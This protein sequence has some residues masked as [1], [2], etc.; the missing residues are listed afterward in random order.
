[1]WLCKRKKKPCVSY[2]LH[3]PSSRSRG[4]TSCPDEPPSG[5]TASVTGCLSTRETARRVMKS[6]FNT[7]TQILIH[8][9]PMLC[10]ILTLLL[11]ACSTF[12]TP[13]TTTRLF[14]PLMMSQ[15]VPILIP[16][17]WKHPMAETLS[18]LTYPIYKCC[19]FIPVYEHEATTLSFS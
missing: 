1:M 15:R 14:K 10:Q 2:H 11:F 19:I 7:N 8:T 9:G 4:K 17:Y 18:L 13:C 5:N 3:E 6:I 16:G 12:F